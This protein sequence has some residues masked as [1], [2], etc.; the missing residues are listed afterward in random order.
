MDDP[1]GERRFLEEIVEDGGGLGG[2]VDA[3]GRASGTEQ[4]YETGRV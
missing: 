3:H 1:A 4:M 2:G